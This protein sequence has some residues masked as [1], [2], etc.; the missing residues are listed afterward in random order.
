MRKGKYSTYYTVLLQRAYK[1]TQESTQNNL[2]ESSFTF[3]Q[4]LVAITDMTIIIV[5]II[6]FLIT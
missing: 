3:N 5:V 2:E 4:Y 1:L 6:D